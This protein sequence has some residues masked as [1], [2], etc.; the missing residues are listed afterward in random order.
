[1]RPEKRGVSIFVNYCASNKTKKCSGTG[2]GL[3]LQLY[4]ARNQV[5]F[6]RINHDL[7]LKNKMSSLA[8][9]APYCCN[10]LLGNRVSSCPH[11][12]CANEPREERLQPQLA[13][14]SVYSFSSRHS[15]FT[16]CQMRPRFRQL[17]TRRHRVSRLQRNRSHRCKTTTLPAMIAADGSDVAPS[18]ENRRQQKGKG[19]H[20]VQRGMVLRRDE[21]ANMTRNGRT[22]KLTRWTTLD[23]LDIRPDELCYEDAS[24]EKVENA[25]GK[26]KLDVKLAVQPVGKDFRVIGKV[27]AQIRR[28][29]DRCTR[30]FEEQ[31][32]GK[33]EVVLDV[34][35]ITE[36]LDS[37]VSDDSRRK[38]QTVN[39]LLQDAEAIE[40]FPASIDEID[41]S[42]HARD[43]IL[44]GVPTRAIC[45]RNCTGI[46][47]V[48]N[49]ELS[50]VRYG[51]SK[52]SE[53]V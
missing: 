45:D 22:A 17:Q 32:D 27:T 52:L 49:D 48:S 29:C 39:S 31:S 25:D 50:S 21:L 11:T 3:D 4:L 24:S 12:N 16:Q 38:G 35:G 19:D 20:P 8:F 28:T 1:M 53:E 18:K 30:V 5:H 36:F 15:C 41:L 9:L 51:G 7:L 34:S 33:F 26:R 14:N 40:P 6:R 2:S 42:P 13:R 37:A 47:I 44:L 10:S 43:A 23:E 46:S